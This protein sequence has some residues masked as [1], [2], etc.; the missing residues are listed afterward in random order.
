[1]LYSFAVLLNGSI[2]FLRVDEM[3]LLLPALDFLLRFWC[4]QVCFAKWHFNFM[5]LA[6]LFSRVDSC[7]LSVNSLPSKLP[8]KLSFTPAQSILPETYV[9]SAKWRITC[10]IYIRCLF[11]V[12]YIPRQFVAKSIFHFRTKGIST[13]N[14]ERPN[15]PAYIHTCAQMTH[16][17]SEIRPRPPNH[18][19]TRTK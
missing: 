9:S 14:H 10:S 1:M 18:E 6:D 5:L 11:P 15:S 17:L 8:F 4:L 12:Q 19:A 3:T 7:C 16:I 2:P 13:G